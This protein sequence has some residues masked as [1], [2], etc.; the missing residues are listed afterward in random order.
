MLA[1]TV[2]RSEDVQASDR[3]DLW[4][5]LMSDTHA[6]MDLTSEQAVDFTAQVRCIQLGPVSVWPATF[7][8]LIWRRTPKLIRQSDPEN[9]HLSLVLQ[10]THGCS[11]GEHQR[12]YVAYDLHNNESSRPYE[13]W[14]Q[15]TGPA[16]LSRSIGVEVPKDVLPLP[17]GRAE[18]AVGLPMSGREGIGAL[19]AQFLVRLAAEADTYQP[20]DAPRLGMVL[21]D[22]FAAVWA[23]TLEAEGSLQPE[24]RRRT[25]LLGMKT[26][27]QQNLHDPAL[28]P[29]TVADAHH[30]SLSHLHRTFQEDGITVAAWIRS[31]RLERICRDLA[32]ADLIAVP[33]HAVAA[34]WGFPRPAEFSRAFRAAHGISPR[35]FRHQAL[36]A[37]VLRRSDEDVR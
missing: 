11:W 20:G 5:E 24:S 8:P 4:R 9:Y 28:S 25:L 29:R 7:G 33:I 16:F 34:R 12:S 17:R 30:I 3:F 36:R 31:R 2:Y 10:G 13:I 23:H 18:C 26:F 35:D 15:G 21:T 14:S 22:L 32:N 1:E 6:P 19:L 37:G 27:I